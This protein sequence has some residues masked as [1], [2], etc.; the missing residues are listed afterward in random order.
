MIRKG[1]DP[2]DMDVSE[3]VETPLQ[4]IREEL[5]E[6]NIHLGFIPQCLPMHRR[7]SLIYMVAV[8]Y[9]MDQDELIALLR[10][11]RGR[12]DVGGRCVIIS[13]S[14]DDGYGLANIKRMAKDAIKFMLGAARLR[15]LG[16]FWGYIRNRHDFLDAMHSAG[17]SQIADGILEK[18]RWNTYW[19]EGR[20]SS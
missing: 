16:Q 18:T 5:P 3:V 6:N 10:N 9:V 8:D 11:L 19:I 15:P 20:N 12:L 14:Y 1:V 4:W 17:F 13:A 7:Y 2:A